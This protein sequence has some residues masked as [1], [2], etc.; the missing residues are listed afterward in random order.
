M[1]VV[2]NMYFTSANFN[3][4]ESFKEAAA[5]WDL[6]FN[7]LSKNGFK[8]HLSIY[9]N[10]YLQVARTSL[11]GKVDQNGLCPPGFRSFVIPINFGSNFI[12]LNRKIEENP[13]LVFPKNGTLDSVSSFEF[14][15][16]VITIEEEHLNVLIE[17]RGY[18]N[19]PRILSSGD[20]LKLHLDASFKQQFHLQVDE[21]LNHFRSAIN[22]SQNAEN[23]LAQGI[24]DLFLNYMDRGKDVVLSRVQ[25]RRDLALK[26]ASAYVQEHIHDNISISDLCSISGVSERTL[27]YAFREIYQVCPKDY[28]KSVKLNKVRS[29]LHK[30]DGQ[31]ISTIAAKYGFWHMGQFAADFRKQFGVLPSA[32]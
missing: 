28:I 20:E 15:V 3:E 31:M 22:H 19:L 7:L 32:V 13:L 1:P 14:D 4:F 9:S 21:F 25:R 27:E 26:K 17:D 2:R 23:H 8:A 12:W 16:Y 10:D 5:N 30:D 11:D 18:M 29:E 6:E 24:V